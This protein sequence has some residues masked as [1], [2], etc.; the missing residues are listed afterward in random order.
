[1]GICNWLKKV[2]ASLPADEALDVNSKNFSATKV[3]VNGNIPPDDFLQLLIS[4]VKKLPDSVF[5]VNANHDIFSV[6]APVAKSYTGI[7]NRRAW[8]CE[9]LRCLASLESSYDWNE[10][11]DMGASNISPQ[12]ME[13]GIFQCSANSMYF[14]KELQELFTKHTGLPYSQSNS[15]CNAFIEEMKSNHEFAIHFMVLLCRITVRT[16]GPLVRGEINKWLNKSSVIEFMGFLGGSIVPD[17]EPKPSSELPWMDIAK[18]E[19]GVKEKN[20]GSNPR[21]IEYHSVTT[22]HATDDN[23]PWCSSF[24]SWCLQKAGYSHTKN[25]WAQSY[26][27]YGEKLS[28]PKIGCIVVFRWSSTS[29]HVGFCVG[30]G[31]G[32]VDLLGGNQSDVSG[33]IVSVKRFT[34]SQVIGYRWPIKK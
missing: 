21:I 11:R 2:T 31:N 32:Y 6:M 8:L 29:G 13:S 17:T 26:G 20:P 12:T 16:H 18:A 19:I 22:L 24:V 7:L 23:T 15:A 28:G 4:V 25:A 27:L 30:S 5:E 34:T 14:G 33:G 1:M 3:K 10:G 9:G